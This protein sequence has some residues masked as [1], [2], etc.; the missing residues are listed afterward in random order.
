MIEVKVLAGSRQKALEKLEDGSFCVHL[1]VAPEKGRA[2]KALIDL[3]ADFFKLPKSHITLISGQ[4][5]RY[6]RLEIKRS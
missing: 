6:K 4:K 5:N 3:M 2:N 1:Q